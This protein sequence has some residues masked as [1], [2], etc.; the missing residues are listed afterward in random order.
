VIAGR[1][2]HEWQDRKYVLSWFGDSEDKAKKAYRKYIHAGMDQGNR[3]ELVGGG[4]IRSLGG[5]PQV[6]S[7]RKHGDRELSDER[8]SGML[9]SLSRSLRRRMIGYHRSSRALSGKRR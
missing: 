4:L 5:W 7:A 2:Q 1:R 6:I 8:I 3:P 9:I